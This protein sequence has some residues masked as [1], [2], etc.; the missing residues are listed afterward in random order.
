MEETSV[1]VST[2]TCVEVTSMEFSTEA[3]MD[4]T[5]SSAEAVEASMEGMEDSMEAFINIDLKC[6]TWR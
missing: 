4:A 1:G 2:K 5:K 6:R 3:S